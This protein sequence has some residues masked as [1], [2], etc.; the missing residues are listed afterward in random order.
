MQKYASPQGVAKNNNKQILLGTVEVVQ[1]VRGSEI[2]KSE[3]PDLS[4]YML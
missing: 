1:R 2:T 3:N 4:F